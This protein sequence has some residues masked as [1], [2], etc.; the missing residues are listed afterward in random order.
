MHECHSTQTQVR[1]QL[2]RV[3]S[4]FP[5]HWVLDGCG[6]KA[7]KA[8]L[9]ANALTYHSFSPAFETLLRSVLLGLKAISESFADSLSVSYN[10]GN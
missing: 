5:P 6:S 9:V 1:G 8:G 2:V 4:V 3:G 7:N 10:H